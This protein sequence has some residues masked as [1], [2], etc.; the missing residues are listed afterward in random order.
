M[1]ARQK[2]WYIYMEKEKYLTL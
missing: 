1:K 2:N